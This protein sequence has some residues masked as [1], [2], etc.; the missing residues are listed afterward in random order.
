MLFV[1]FFAKKGIYVDKYLYLCK[2][3]LNTNF[4]I[5]FCYG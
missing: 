4:E 5:Y 2:L 1:V 3:F